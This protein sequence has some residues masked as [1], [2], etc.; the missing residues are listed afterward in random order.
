MRKYPDLTQADETIME[1]LWRDGEVSS[2]AILR[3]VADT[4]RWSRQ[5][6]GTYLSR[7]MEKGLV[8]ARKVSER[9]YHYYPIVTRETYA[10]D[11]TNSFFTKYY[12]SLPHMVAGIVK[13]AG[14]SDRD[15]D[16]LEALIKEI[17]SKDG[18]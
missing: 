17:R 6:V 8:G 13:T 14:I 16:E 18:K 10:A 11:K 4:L 2:A 5:T 12:D 7:L 1:I 9:A 15:L 3:E